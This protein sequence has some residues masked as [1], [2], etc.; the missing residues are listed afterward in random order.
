MTHKDYLILK[1]SR[2]YSE[3]VCIQR[4]EKELWFGERFYRFLRKMDSLC[5]MK[6]KREWILLGLSRCT[7]GY[8]QWRLGWLAFYFRIPTGN[9]LKIIKTK[10]IHIYLAYLLIG[11]HC[12]FGGVHM[13][14]PRKNNGILKLY[15]K[16]LFPLYQVLFTSLSMLHL[17]FS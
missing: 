2:M 17:T 5:T 8:K 11:Y 1:I 16:I 7:W 9:N 3:V 6:K 13:W 14:E 15:S 4:R 10:E 12:T